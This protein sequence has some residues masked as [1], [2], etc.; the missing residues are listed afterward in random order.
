MS[1]YKGTYTDNLN[2]SKD[3]V[4]DSYDVGRVNSNSDKI[5]NWAGEVNKQLNKMANNKFDKNN[6]ANNLTTNTEG[7]VLDARQAQALTN[8]INS[9]TDIGTF[10]V[11]LTAETPL[12]YTINFSKTLRGIPNLNLVLVSSSISVYQYFYSIKDI[13]STKAVIS[14]RSNVSISGAVFKYSATCV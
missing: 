5:D 12:E 1:D 13:T 11:G 3:D 14:I 10:V 7:Y 8:I 9:L 4:D 6:I 2:L